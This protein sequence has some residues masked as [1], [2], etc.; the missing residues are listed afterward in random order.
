MPP[1]PGVSGEGLIYTNGNLEAHVAALLFLGSVG[2]VGLLL[3]TAVVLY[4]K[5]RKWVRYPLLACGA[6]VLG[7]GVLLAAFSLA[8]RERTLG[9]GEEKH[10]CELDCHIAYSVQGVER[11][12]SIGDS[13]ASGE[14]YLLRVRTRFDET[15]IA[16]WRPRDASL[17]PDPP[18][19]LVVDADGRK[20]AVSSAGQSAWEAVH[21]SQPSA[22]SPLRPGESYERTLVFDVPPNARSPRLLLK[23]DG[24]P[25]LVLIG[26]E[27]TPGHKKTYLGL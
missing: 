16:P 7:Y 2:L 9:R 26:D 4:F 6:V 17:T 25:S 22:W 18:L 23:D 8:S 10:F 19:P 14:F 20:Y 24:G 5:G 12:K 15:T 11:M 21:G 13:T 1:V 27:S 3:V